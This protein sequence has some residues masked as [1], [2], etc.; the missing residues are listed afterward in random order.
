MSV[1]CHRSPPAR[2]CVPMPDRSAWTKT[3]LAYNAYLREAPGLALKT[4]PDL[5]P[6]IDVAIQSL[7]WLTQ[8]SVVVLGFDGFTTDG[9]YLYPSL[10]HIADFSG[11]PPGRWRVDGPRQPLGRRVAS[12]AH[13]LAWPGSVRRHGDRVR[14]RPPGHGITL[15][16]RGNTPSS[17]R[18]KG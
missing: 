8:H 14:R 6:S 5:Y 12:R 4:G 10:S 13:S 16:I 15:T 9:Q 1:A 17:I 7:D 2:Y 11:T 3:Q 18:L